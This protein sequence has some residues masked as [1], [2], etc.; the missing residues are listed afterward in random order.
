MSSFLTVNGFHLK[1]KPKLEQTLFHFSLSREIQRKRQWNS[2][3]LLT[4]DLWGLLRVPELS[5]AKITNGA[6]ENTLFPIEFTSLKYKWVYDHSFHS[7]EMKYTSFIVCLHQ[8]YISV[9]NQ[10]LISLLLALISS[11]VI[12]VLWLPTCLAL[13]PTP[14]LKSKHV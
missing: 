5:E 8:T 7:R 10:L 14:H 1:E 12:G 6:L 3:S 13:L 2:K 11:S 9:V 4:V